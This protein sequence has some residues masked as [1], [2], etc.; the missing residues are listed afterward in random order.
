MVWAIAR[1]DAAASSNRLTD[2]LFRIGY[3]AIA[4]DRS[5][6]RHGVTCDESGLQPGRPS[7]GF[8]ILPFAEIYTV[9]DLVS[10]DAGGAPT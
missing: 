2:S 7:S 5:K 10:I 1:F 9:I 6:S 4:A 3:N 8:S